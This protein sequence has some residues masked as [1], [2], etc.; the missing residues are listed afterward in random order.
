MDMGTN[1]LDIEVRPHRDGTRASTLDANTQPPLP[2]VDVM[3]PSGRRDQLTIP[4]INLSISGYEPDS[5]RDSH[6]RPSVTR[7]QEILIMPQL[8]GPIS[9]PTR[10]PIRRR[11]QEE[12]RFEEQEYSQG[13]T[14]V[15]GASISQ[16]REY[17]GES[18]DND[19]VD[20]RPYRDRRPPERGRY[21]S[22]SGRPPDQ[23]RYPDRGF[24][25]RG[26]P[27]GN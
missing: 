23:R 18:S 1:T 21:P 10:D 26:Y 16:R 14:Y 3:L 6:T 2:L 22:Q 27:N 4:H 11:V 19:N 24:P 15:Q 7:A 8:D 20:R 25:R 12:S 13:G 17:P 5:L 9:L